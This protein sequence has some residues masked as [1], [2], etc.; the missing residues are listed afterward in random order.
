MYTLAEHQTYAVNMMMGNSALAL[1]Y[2]MGTGKTAIALSFIREAVLAGEIR[3]A[4]VICPA[5]LVP[6]W[7]ASIGKMGEFGWTKGE[8]DVVRSITTVISISSTWKGY[9]QE[10]RHRNGTT[11]RR[12]RYRINPTIDRPW[13]CIIIDEAH[14]L[15]DPTS[16]QTETCLKLALY[17]KRRYIMTGT[18]DCG[19][20][21]TPMYRKLYGQIKFLKP[22]AWESYAE[23]RR[24]YVLAYDRYD[25]PLVYDSAGCEDLKK[26]FAIVARLRDCFD[27]PESTETVLECPLAE[28]QAYKDLLKHKAE[29]FGFTDPLAGVS[30][31]KLL[32]VCSGFVKGDDG[33]LYLLRTS[34]DDVLQSVLDGTE[35][36]VVVFCAYTASIDR[37]SRLLDDRRE[38]YVVFDGRSN[39]PTWK[40]F[41]ERADIRV[42]VGQYQKGGVGVDLF[43]ACTTVF[44]EPTQSAMLLEQARA[45]TLRKGQTRH[46]QYIHLVTPGTVEERTSEAVRQGVSVSAQLLDQWAREESS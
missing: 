6:N 11:S 25:K 30:H 39:E 36:K 7:N 12:R 44:Y 27:L 3:N 14:A 42:F 18:P 40:A 13:D 45:R 41:Q 16:V 10:V 28:R 8:I 31:V 21:D 20:G 2:E 1:Y 29:R 24:R 5:P 19:S 9:W 22:D 46:V 33:N 15:G 37:V 38:S 26:R 4:L 23:W 43:A 17:A 32:Q 34:K 35:G